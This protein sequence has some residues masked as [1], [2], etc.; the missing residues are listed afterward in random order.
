MVKVKSKY[1]CQ[2]CGASYSK[3][4]GRCENCGEWNTLLEQVATTET[5]VKSAL[6][7]GAVSGKKL[8]AVSINTIE[9]SDAGSRLSTGFPDLDTVLGGGILLGSVSLLAGQPGMGKSTILMQVCSNVA[10]G[11]HKVLY[12]SGEESAGQVKLRAVRLGAASDKL[13]FASSTSG[14]D[15]AKTFGWPESSRASRG[16]CFEF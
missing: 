10:N 14:N 4:A 15:I 5:E 12:V 2:N 11:G 1:V 9:P 6:A 13:H 16:C 3:W 7:K 8:D